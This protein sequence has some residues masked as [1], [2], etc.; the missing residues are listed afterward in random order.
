MANV[1]LNSI[2]YNTATVVDATTITSLT[3][4]RNDQTVYVHTTANYGLEAIGTMA[5]V[6]AAIVTAGRTATDATSPY[7]DSKVFFA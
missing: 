4:G 7:I 1:T 2:H 6:K 3:V 5:A